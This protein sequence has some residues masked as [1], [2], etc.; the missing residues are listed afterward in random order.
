MVESTGYCGDNQYLVMFGSVIQYL[1]FLTGV[2]SIKYGYVVVPKI[3]EKQ[4]VTLCCLLAPDN[5]CDTD[6][7]CTP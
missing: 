4:D 3:N 2:H 5:V 7:A 6:S 1:L